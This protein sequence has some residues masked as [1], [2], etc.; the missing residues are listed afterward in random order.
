MS[1]PPRFAV[2]PPLPRRQRRLLQRVMWVFMGLI[3]TFLLVTLFAAG[4]SSGALLAV[5]LAVLPVP[6]Y[7]LAVLALDRF[8]PEPARLLL[9]AFLWGATMAAFLA[10][11]ANELGGTYLA[12]FFDAQGGYDRLALTVVLVAPVAEEVLKGFA[13]VALAW[14]RRDEFDGPVDGIVYGALVGLGFAMTENAL[15]YVDAFAQGGAPRATGL[16]VLRGVFTG[17]SHPLYTSLTGIGVGFAVARR[18]GLARVLFPLAGLAAGVALH[19]LWNYSAMAA[20]QTD[21]AMLAAVYFGLMLPAAAVWVWFAFRA[22][23]AE[24]TLIA[25]HL[26]PDVA[27]GVLSAALH[28]ELGTLAGRAAGARMALR[29]GGIPAMR[30]R[31]SFYLAASEEGLRR[32]RAGLGREPDH[33][34]RHDYLGP[35]RPGVAPPALPSP[36]SPPPLT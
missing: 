20:E 19:H 7:V 6:V 35:Y 36:A 5:S 8:E 3:V 25:R 33:G 11:F 23:R 18:P 2:P 17:F 4:G 1:V 14:R 16:F 28:A 31:R 24:G 9:W 12:A 15:Y 29:Q 34:S 10:G 26:A 27:A 30:A 21:G 13:L 22:L 32:W